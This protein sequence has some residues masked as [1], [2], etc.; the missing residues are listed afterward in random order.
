MSDA[1][2]A[3]VFGI[4]LQSGADAPAPSVLPASAPV[5]PPPA[6]IP[7][8]GSTPAAAH[9]PATRRLPRPRRKLSPAA[10]A[11]LSA[12]MKV[13]WQRAKGKGPKRQVSARSQAGRRQTESGAP[14][15]AR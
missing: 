12:A 2:V 7:A 4:E 1:E 14:A 13:R 6:A 15:Q 8:S 10:R 3:D 9:S 11:R 5:V